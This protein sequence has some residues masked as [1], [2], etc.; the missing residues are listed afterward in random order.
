MAEIRSMPK[1][2]P[3][4]S[5]EIVGSQLLAAIG[6]D[7]ELMLPSPSPSLSELREHVRE[8]ES[9]VNDRADTARQ[10]AALLEK[11]RREAQQQ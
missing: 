3:Q 6:E 1:P 8:L 2:P 10:L 11:R 9:R 7:E 4:K 5:S